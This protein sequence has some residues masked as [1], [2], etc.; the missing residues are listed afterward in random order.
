VP[1]PYM[2]ALYLL[3]RGYINERMFVNL[4]TIKALHPFG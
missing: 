1:V 2:T 4:Y 3:F